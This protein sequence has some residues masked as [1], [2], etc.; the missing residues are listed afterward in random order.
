MNAQLRRQLTEVPVASFATMC[1]VVNLA[2]FAQAEAKTR[3]LQSNLNE[4]LEHK[5]GH[6]YRQAI[7]VEQKLQAG[8]LHFQLGCGVSS[9]VWLLSGVHARACVSQARCGRRRTCRLPRV[10]VR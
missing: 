9:K 10:E 5:D 2:L 4:L 6:F 8:A 7:E 1:R 3:Q